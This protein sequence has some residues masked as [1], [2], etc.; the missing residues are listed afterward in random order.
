MFINGLDY[1]KFSQ[2]LK[3]LIQSSNTQFGVDNAD[4]TAFMLKLFSAA[5]ATINQNMLQATLDSTLQT[6][7]KDSAIYNHLS[8]LGG[9]IK[10]KIPAKTTIRLEFS[11]P[12]I[13]QHILPMNTTFDIE[14]LTWYLPQMQIIPQRTSTIDFALIQGKPMTET[15]IGNGKLFQQ[16]AFGSNFNVAD[17]ETM[18]VISQGMLLKIIKDRTSLDFLQLA[19]GQDLAYVTDATDGSG[20]CVLVF[21]DGTYRY[22]P[23][24]NEPV[25]IS[26]YETEGSAGNQSLI[27]AVAELTSTSLPIQ[28]NAYTITGRASGSDQLNLDYMKWIQPALYAANSRAVRADD[29]KAWILN[30]TP[31]IDCNVWGEYTQSRKLN[32]IDLRMMNKVYYTPLLSST[33]QQTDQIDGA[34]LTNQIWNLSAR[35]IIDGS[36]EMIITDKTTG[37]Q[38][39]GKWV[40]GAG[41]IANDSFYNNVINSTTTTVTSNGYATGFPP[42]NIIDNSPNT[43]WKSADNNEVTSR[44]MLQLSST[45]FPQPPV[46]QPPSSIYAIRIQSNAETDRV[47][48]NNIKSFALIGCEVAPTNLSQRPDGKIVCYQKFCRDNEQLDKTPWLFFDRPATYVDST[49][50]I[51]RPYQIFVMEILEFWDNSEPAIIGG[52]EMLCSAQ[53]DTIKINYDAGSIDFTQ[54]GFAT[55]NLHFSIRF[56]N[57]ADTS[58]YNQQVENVLEDKKCMQVLLEYTP[59]ICHVEHVKVQIVLKPSFSDTVSLENNIKS[60]IKN[61]FKLGLDSLGKKYEPSQ[62]ICMLKD[63]DGVQAVKLLEPMYQ[64]YCTMNEFIFLMDDIEITFIRGSLV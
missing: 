3:D 38:Q 29:Y 20:R 54:S 27:G 33:A 49:S 19:Q 35:N 28:F 16:F 60:N 22:S 41:Y 7:I 1:D 59:P 10:R 11:F 30:S 24:T 55:S 52:V 26:Y 14:G 15:Y 47:N 44:I 48:R 6:A 25:V 34:M 42:T 17:D 61:F 50:G 58:A 12:T 64:Y 5:M 23:P 39:P 4:V 46:G 31:V 2:S 43:Y 32:E 36:I 57:S 45:V 37:N 40:D 63:M 8:T 53:T 18:I 62:L 21:G 13:T 56:C 9:H 51:T